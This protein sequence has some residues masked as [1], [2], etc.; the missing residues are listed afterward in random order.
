MQLAGG[1]RVAIN[2]TLATASTSYVKL[3]MRC[4]AGTVTFYVDGVA[5]A[6]TVASSA[7][8]FPLNALVA[9]AFATKCGSAAANTLHIDWW[10][11]AQTRLAN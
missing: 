1:A 2:S 3:G 5:D 11:M 10:R 7:T 8:N 6:T 9:P 4:V